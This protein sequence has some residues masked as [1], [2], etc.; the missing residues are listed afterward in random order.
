MSTAEDFDPERECF[1]ITDEEEDIS[2]TGKPPKK[3]GISK[4][5]DKVS[6]IFKRPPAYT[7][8]YS[9]RDEL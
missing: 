4:L 9:T 5:C 6:K 2:L 1:V 3:T 8:V 7:D